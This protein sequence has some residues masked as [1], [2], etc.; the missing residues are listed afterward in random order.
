[1]IQSKQR[2]L[3]PLPTPPLLHPP[4][5]Q[6]LAVPPFIQ[7]DNID[8]RIDQREKLCQR[9]RDK[10]LA[11]IEASGQVEGLDIRSFQSFHQAKSL[12]KRSKNR[13]KQLSS[14]SESERVPRRRHKNHRKKHRSSSKKSSRRLSLK[15]SESSL[16]SDSEKSYKSPKRSHH[17]SYYSHYPVKSTQANHSSP[18]VEYPLLDPNFHSSLS[19]HPRATT[20]PSQSLYQSPNYVPLPRSPPTMQ[21]LSMEPVAFWFTYKK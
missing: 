9:L 18:Y 10:V 19:A 13:Y 14:S 17:R 3:T 20:T 12:S 11:E 2:S 15:R 7:V 8:K 16:S 6:Q 21:H 4:S 1:M 5:H